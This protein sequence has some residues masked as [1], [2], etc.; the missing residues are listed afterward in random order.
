[1]VISGV[2]IEDPLIVQ[3]TQLQ[4]NGAGIRYKAVFKVYVASLY[5]KLKISTSDEFYAA[6]GPKR[7]SITLLRDVASSE[8]GKTFARA[9]DGLHGKADVARLIPELTRLEQD[10]AAREKLVAGETFTIDW[11]PGTGTIVTVMGKPL[12]APVREVDFYNTV[13]DIWLGPAAADW[14]LRDSLLGKGR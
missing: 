5:V 10:F 1:M 2:N 4:L 12:G 11:V 9:L 3:G 6:P 14:K 8:I 7:L 13:L